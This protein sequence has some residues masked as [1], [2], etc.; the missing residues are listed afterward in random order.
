MI[1]NKENHIYLECLNYMEEA[2][3]ELQKSEKEKGVYKN[4]QNVK[5]AYEIAYNAILMAW[6]E[7]YQQALKKYPNFDPEAA[8]KKYK[9]EPNKPHK[10]FKL[11]KQ[12]FKIYNLQSDVNEQLYLIRDKQGTTSEKIVQKWFKN[13]YKIIELIK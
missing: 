9:N 1:E 7:Y 5:N 2:K 10:E 8:L 4:I 6:C 11:T 13:V 12:Q 3:L